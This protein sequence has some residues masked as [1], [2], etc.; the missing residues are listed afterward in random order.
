M[1]A[2]VFAPSV[3]R[4]SRHQTESVPSW[5]GI[6]LLISLYDNPN[7]RSACPQ[8][9]PLS[10]FQLI[11]PLRAPQQLRRYLGKVVVDDH[12]PMLGGGC[13]RN[14]WVA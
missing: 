5:T 6:T 10:S 13:D 11:P 1:R 3:S 9:S 12:E 8:L 7:R 14:G 4:M 2:S